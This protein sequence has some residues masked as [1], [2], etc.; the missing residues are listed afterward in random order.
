MKER[1]LDGITIK[2]AYNWGDGRSQLNN[3]EFDDATAVV[4][5]ATASL[6]QIK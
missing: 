4:N 2:D 6:Y 3:V 1:R 5:Y